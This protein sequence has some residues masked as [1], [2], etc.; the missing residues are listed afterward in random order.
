MSNYKHQHGSALAMQWLSFALKNLIYDAKNSG[1]LTNQLLGNATSIN[2]DNGANFVALGGVQVLNFVLPFA[3][4]LSLK[5]IIEISTSTVT[6]GHNLEKLYEK[7]SSETKRKL[8]T[9]FINQQ[10][11]AVIT[12]ERTFKKFLADHKTDFVSWRY[13]DEPIESLVC[14]EEKML[15]AICTILTV[16]DM[17]K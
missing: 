3:V 13:L 11:I 16:H 6:R 15:L 4:E 7:L 8:E 10:K 9:E 2:G 17:Y 14:E 5:S 1:R 12:E